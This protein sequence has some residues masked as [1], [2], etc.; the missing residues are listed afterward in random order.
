MTTAKIK[1]Q[2]RV[3]IVTG[4]G[5]GIGRA[6]VDVLLADGWCVAA[7]DANSGA[8][9][10]LAAQLG[11]REDVLTAT[12]D[13]TDEPAVIALVDEIANEFGR[14]DGVVNSAG[15][16]AD[17]PALETPADLFRKILDVNVV[18]SFIVARAAAKVM[19]ASKT[20]G[21]IVNLASV[22]GLRGS[23]GRVAYGASKGAIV[24]MTQVLANDLARH[25]IR[26]N[27]IAPGPIETPLVKTLHS[28][29]DRKLWLRYVPANRY[30]APED[31]AH[32][33]AFLLDGRRSGFIT[34]T[35]LPVD[36]GFA[37]A[38][39]IDGRD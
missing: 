21:S 10:T 18:G 11:Q 20:G 17:K 4:A 34:A 24:T 27:A 19:V 22:S 9:E 7:V 31:V 30:G 12:V 16:A 6:M 39:I 3:V 1:T 29:A 2:Q 35:V 28:A 5:S 13:V 37:G 23:K 38:G 33:A 36:G 32:A 26:V 8:V 25:G 14:I 15:I